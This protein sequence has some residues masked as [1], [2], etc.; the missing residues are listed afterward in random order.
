MPLTRETT[1]DHGQFSSHLAET[2]ARAIRVAS[3]P[4]RSSPLTS[5]AALEA[6]RTRNLESTY[7]L[8]FIDSVIVRVRENDLQRNRRIHIAVGILPDGSKDIIAFWI[9]ASAKGFWSSAVLELRDRGVDS[10]CLAVVE[11]PTGCGTALGIIYPNTRVLASVEHFVRRATAFVPAKE[12]Q[13]IARDL[14]G[15]FMVENLEA[16]ARGFDEFAATKTA[17]DHPSTT[18]FWRENWHEMAS[19]FALPL[20]VRLTVC[21]NTAVDSVIEK[22][23]R[24]GLKKR[25]SF[26]SA[27]AA[28]REMILVLRDANIS[29]KVAPNRWLPVR[30]ELESL[31]HQT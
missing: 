2:D 29:W 6:W 22:L 9:E 27:E 4:R 26:P 30:R 7:S 3:L 8:V 20:A 5:D 24:R 18:A 23:R 10:V 21:S 13:Q 17:Q 28:I 11:D 25:A 1:P 15:L 19:F 16:A 12:R 31:E 14:R